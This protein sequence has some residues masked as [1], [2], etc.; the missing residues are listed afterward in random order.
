MH[1]SLSLFYFFSYAG[2]DRYLCRLKQSAIDVFRKCVFAC[3]M[4]TIVDCR[5]MYSAAYAD[6]KRLSLLSSSLTKPASMSRFQKTP[7]KDS[8]SVSGNMPAASEDAAKAF[9]AAI[10]KY[11]LIRL[12]LRTSCAILVSTFSTCATGTFC[13]V[14]FAP[15]WRV[16]DVLAVVILLMAVMLAFAD[17][18]GL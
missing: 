5:R 15:H 10:I 18:Y 9:A 2:L 8:E 14:N 3:P 13:A 12:E 7:V 6:L 1:L 17:S 16:N 11:D 4:E